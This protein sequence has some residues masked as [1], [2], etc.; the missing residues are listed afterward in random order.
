MAMTGGT[1]GKVSVYKYKELAY[2]NQRVGK[3]EV[4]SSKLNYIFLYYL[5]N[6]FGYQ[7]YIKLTAFGGAQPNISDTEMVDYQ[8]AL[9]SIEEQIM[10]TNYLS[11]ETTKIDQAI[12]LKTAHI[13]K[14]KEYKSVLINDVVTGKVRV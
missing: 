12:A 10:I 8:I 3:F 1:I 7:E 2:V 4:V 6:S 11:K 9:P 14:L 5:L 13:E